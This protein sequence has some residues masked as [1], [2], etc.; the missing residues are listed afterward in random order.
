MSRRIREALEGLVGSGAFPSDGE[1]K[2]GG[3][4]F[5]GGLRSGPVVVAPSTP[6]QVA[7][8]MGKASEEGWSVLPAGFGRWLAGGGRPDVQIV[9]ST[10]GMR[11]VLEYEPADLTFTVGAG[12][13]LAS[14][15]EVTS[16]HRQWLPLDP[17]GGLEGSLGA[18]TALGG[19]GALRHSFGGPRDHVLGLTMVSGDG[20][21][22]RWGGKVVKNV[23]GFDLTRLMVGSWGTLGIVTSVSGRL[24]P[25]PE[26]D[27]T[28][29]FG[30]RRAAALLP[31]ARAMALSPLPLGAVELME[32]LERAEGEGGLPNRESTPAGLV[33]RLLGSGAQVTEMEGRICSD[34][35]G[36]YG[37]PDRFRGGDSLAFHDGLTSWEDGAEL[38][39]RLCLLPS[40]L[41][42]LLEEAEGI[43]RLAKSSGSGRGAGEAGLDDRRL[44]RMSAHVGAG[45]L[46]VAVSGVTWDA[47]NLASWVG[48]LRSLR[49]R[50]EARGGT[51]T[52]SYGPPVLVGELGAWGR[53]GGEKRI[54]AGLEAQFDPMGVLARGGRTS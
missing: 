44:V 11:K 38:V 49:G 29:V 3:W 35:A 37:D 26:A 18:A 40:E 42:S 14:L 27:T 47:R 39:M 36:E 41:G 2:A 31:A 54:V 32:P 10:R 7:L 12:V 21:V 17:P 28:L 20:R 43:E 4:D 5:A 50:L 19:A 51:L 8:V 25:L 46:R 34:L 1:L 6:D 53:V 48:E 30:G 45:L 16:L 52:V 13:S 22:L 15:R 24:F 33:L 23:A 9:V